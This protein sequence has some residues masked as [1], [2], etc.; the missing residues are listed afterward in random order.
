[1]IFELEVRNYKCCCI[2]NWE[3]YFFRCIIWLKVM[4]TIFNVKPSL[5]HDE[6]VPILFEFVTEE[7]IIWV[8]FIFFFF[9]LQTGKGKYADQ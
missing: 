4:N 2:E 5:K 9:F 3:K 1:M 7:K 6:I 8:F